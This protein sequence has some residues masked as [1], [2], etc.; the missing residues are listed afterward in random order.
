MKLQYK[1]IWTDNATNDLRQILLYIQYDKVSA[2]KVFIK[3][4]KSDVEKLRKHPQL[5]RIVPELCRKDIREII[6]KKY[7]VVY[8]I[9]TK[10][11]IILTVFEGHKEFDSI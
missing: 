6:V 7:R 1:I 2:A 4:I 10:K 8:K 5:G 9:E 11:I 3:K